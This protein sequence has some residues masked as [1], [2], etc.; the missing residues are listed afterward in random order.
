MLLT[1]FSSV[2]RELTRRCDT[3]GY[4]PLLTEA[5]AAIGAAIDAGLVTLDAVL[6]QVRRCETADE[7]ADLMLHLA[8][9]APREEPPAR[10][11]VFRVVGLPEGATWDRTELRRLAA[12]GWRWTP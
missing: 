5:A 1:P 8:A 9:A 10:E 3:A 6:D 11:R 4:S 12:G 2:E 7:L